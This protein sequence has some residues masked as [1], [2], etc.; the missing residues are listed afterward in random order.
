[1]KTEEL[2]ARDQKRQAQEKPNLRADEV[3]V[4]ERVANFFDNKVIPGVDGPLVAFIIR[5]ELIRGN[6]L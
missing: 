6:R 4:L 5:E 2:I 3:A 1:M